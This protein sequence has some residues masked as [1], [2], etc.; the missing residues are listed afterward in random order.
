MEI[1]AERLRLRASL[2]LGRNL[3]YEKGELGFS[4][5]PLFGTEAEGICGQS[6]PVDLRRACDNGEQSLCHFKSVRRNNLQQNR[7]L[8]EVGLSSVQE[9]SVLYLFRGEMRVRA[10]LWSLTWSSHCLKAAIRDFNIL[11]CKV[12]ALRHKSTKPLL[13]LYTVF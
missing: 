2:A 10:R 4:P 6:R 13:F 11:S 5:L 3:D 8:P 9:F 7:Y 12:Q 1:G